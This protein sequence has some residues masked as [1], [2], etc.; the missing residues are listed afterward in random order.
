MTLSPEGRKLL[1]DFEVGGGEDYFRKFLS[2]PT[3]PG[4][5]SGVTI[6]VG[7]D[8]GYNSRAQ[9]DEA[10]GSVLADEWSAILVEALGL[11]AQSARDWLHSNPDARGIEITW[12]QALDVFER[13]TV[14]RF[15]L[16]AL[17]IYPQIDA[18]PE[19]AR[20]ALISLVFNRGAALAGDRRAEMV[21]IQN[22]LRDGRLYDVPDLLRS[23]KRLWPNTL[24][25]QKRR[26][27][28][29]DLFHK[30]IS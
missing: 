10:W 13:I 30:S 23:M 26:D 1:I 12:R 18:L 22:A 7:F 4:E 21:G 8:L 19:A 17:R 9:F 11:K 20:D 27:A 25:L 2:R 14:P 3:C 6:G 5:Q 24:G 16:Q 28:E 29:A 15:Y